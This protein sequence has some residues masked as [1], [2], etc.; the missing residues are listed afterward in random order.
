MPI[1]PN[2]S[3]KT[4]PLGETAEFV[5]VTPEMASEWLKRN[6]KNNRNLRRMKIEGYARDMASGNWMVTGE[7]V[8]FDT[9][10]N[11]VDGQN[12]LQAVVE[13]DCS[14][15][16]LVV[17]NV[18][19]DAMVVLDSGAVRSPADALVISGISDRAEAK[20][21]AAVARVYKSYREGILQHAMSHPG[22]Q[23]MTKVEITDMVLSIPN[24]DY[25]ARFAKTVYRYLRLPVGSIGVAYLEFSAIESADCE[26]FF[27]RIINGQQN[28]AGDPFT[29]LNRRVA[30]E[31]M[32]GGR[33]TP[34]GMGLFLL[35]RTWNAYRRQEPLMKFQL[36]SASSGWTPLPKPE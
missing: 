23:T 26:E 34:E 14:V 28:G 8:K 3:A 22:R 5:I 35:F 21:V 4:G 10:G 17:R 31:V 29:T 2:K 19:A 18:S 9:E 33:R 11:L 7:A 36:G 13:S 25:A 24:I 30:A 20:D 6:V 16:M 1:L 15:W 32:Q 27:S 12:R